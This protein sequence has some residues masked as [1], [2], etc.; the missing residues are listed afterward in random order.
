MVTRRTWTF[1]AIAMLL[2]LGTWLAINHVQDAPAADR[3]GQSGPL[4]FEF[5]VTQV[6]D[7]KYLGDTP[8]LI[9][10]GGNVQGRPGLALDD[11]VYR[12]REKEEVGYITA[13]TWDRTKQSLEIEFSPRPLKKIAVGD[14]VLVHFKNRD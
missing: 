9:G 10:R 11:P 12:G 7:A 6:I 4:D 14:H 5:D 2:V 3:E 1:A 8:S 13:V